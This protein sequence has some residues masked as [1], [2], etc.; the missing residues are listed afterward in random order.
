MASQKIRVLED[1]VEL[2]GEQRPE[3]YETEYPVH[4]ARRLALAGRVEILPADH[5]LTDSTIEANSAST[6]ATQT[7]EEPSEDDTGTDTAAEGDESTSEDAGAGSDDSDDEDSEDPTEAEAA[8]VIR[9]ALESDDWDAIRD[10]VGEYTDLG[11]VGLS[12]A[13]AIEALE[14]KLEDLE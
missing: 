14:S 3:G 6:R 11:V 9:T 5:S 10:A 4:A 12:K 8:H 7:G 1:G 2:H 13:D